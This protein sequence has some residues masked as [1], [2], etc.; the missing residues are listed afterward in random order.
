MPSPTGG[1]KIYVSLPVEVEDT[2]TVATLKQKIKVMTK[3]PPEQQTIRSEDIP[4][5]HVLVDKNKLKDYKISIK[6]NVY[7]WK[8]FEIS[9][10]GKSK[11]YK[12]TT[13][14][15]NTVQSLK[16]EIKPKID[17]DLNCLSGPIKLR[18]HTTDGTAVELRDNETLDECGI[19]GVHDI[20][21]TYV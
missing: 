19:N 2:D 7:L 16:K 18:R 3:I 20:Y 8:K 21:V 14:G 12:V 10:W 4:N 9:V 13:N 17:E 11:L 5:G 6:S 15:S 1:F